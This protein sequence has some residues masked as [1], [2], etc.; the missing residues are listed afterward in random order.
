MS[1][2]PA[3]SATGVV[4]S[5]AVATNR[6]DAC[7]MAKSSAE[8]LAKFAAREIA[9]PNLVHIV[10]FG[11]CNCE[12]GVSGSASLPSPFWKCAVDAMWSDKK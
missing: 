12:Q 9:N 5:S 1:T 4:S 11:E 10:S 6:F 2:N 8:G 7:Q 3:M